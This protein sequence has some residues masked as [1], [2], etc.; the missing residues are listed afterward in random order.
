VRERLKEEW[1]SV[2]GIGRKKKHRRGREVEDRGGGE[3][4]E[5]LQKVYDHRDQ[6]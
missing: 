2:G 4:G 5:R 3:E 1:V 6:I